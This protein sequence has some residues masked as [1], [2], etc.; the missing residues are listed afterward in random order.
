MKQNTNNEAG[1][2]LIE[3]LVA[4]AIL[5]VALTPLLGIFTHGLKVAEKANKLTLA[6]SLARDMT[7]EIRSLPFWEPNNSI[8][9]VSKDTYFPATNVPQSFGFEEGTYDVNKSRSEQLDDVDDY[10]G[11]CR[12]PK[13]DCTGKPAG[14]CKPDTPTNPS[15]LEAMSKLEPAVADSFKYNGVNGRPN[16]PGLTQS[17]RVYNISLKHLNDEHQIDFNIPVVYQGSTPSKKDFLYYDLR[18]AARL[19]TMTMI[20]EKGMTPKRAAG[21]TRVKIIEVTVQYDGQIAAG[22]KYTDIGMSVLPVSQAK[23]N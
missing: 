7:E 17:V 23:S 10:N 18:D 3:L 2:S 19:R 12:G 20:R 13:C 11:W 5:G 15:V 8:N 21:L 4:I 22:I 14:I 6:T 9:G 16:Y 1:F